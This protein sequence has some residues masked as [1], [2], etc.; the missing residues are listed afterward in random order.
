MMSSDLL[1]PKEAV[2]AI[3]TV[4]LVTV[5]PSRSVAEL[6]QVQVPVAS[7]REWASPPLSGQ[8]HQP[9]ARRLL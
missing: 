5:V 4:V 6:L 1:V 9:V 3:V 2:A 8:R 7:F